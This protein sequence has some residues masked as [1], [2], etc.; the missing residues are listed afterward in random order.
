MDFLII[1]K[2]NVT[3]AADYAT[4]KSPITSQW[5]S[6][7]VFSDGDPITQQEVENYPWL[8]FE[9]GTGDFFDMMPSLE[10]AKE[11]IVTIYNGTYTIFD[12]TVDRDAI[13]RYDHAMKVI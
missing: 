11:V 6:T 13:R 9:T 2:D 7:D 3:F 10:T 12:E 5:V 8:A 1:H 4:C